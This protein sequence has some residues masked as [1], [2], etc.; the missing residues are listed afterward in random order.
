M[1]G[2]GECA[3]APARVFSFQKPFMNRLKMPPVFIY[4]HS[5]EERV[6]LNAFGPLL[7]V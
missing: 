2:D 1:V 6:F 3:E 7:S 4:P 5:V